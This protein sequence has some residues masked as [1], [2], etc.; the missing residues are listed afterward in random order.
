VAVSTLMACVFVSPYRARD[1]QGRSDPPCRHVPDVQT[2]A[3]A[4]MATVFEM[5][6]ARR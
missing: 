4:G 5:F 6:R 3:A 1:R 2:T